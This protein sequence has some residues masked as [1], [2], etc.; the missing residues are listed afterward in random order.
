MSSKNLTLHLH[1]NDNVAIAKVAL[2]SGM[3]IVMDLTSNEHKQLSIEDDIPPGHKVALTKL[4]P[5]EIVRRYGQVIGTA[6]QEINPG[7]HIHTHNLAIPDHLKFEIMHPQKAVYDIKYYQEALAKLGYVEPRHSA[8]LAGYAVDL[9]R[10]WY[11]KH[12]PDTHRAIQRAVGDLFSRGV[13]NLIQEETHWH[14][15]LNPD[16]VRHYEALCRQWE[17]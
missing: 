10:L 7:E 5:G 11:L 6:S 3:E 4:D 17:R 2:Q 14:L 16:H 15:C 9:E 1:P 12:A 13:I 8:H